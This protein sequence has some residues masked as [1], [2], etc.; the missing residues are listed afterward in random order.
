MRHRAPSS[1]EPRPIV[2]LTSDF[3]LSDHYVA[4]MKAVLVREFPPARLIDITHNVPRHD[5]LCG[6]ITIER[7]VDGFTGGTTHL[8]VVDPGVGTDRRLI[9][10]RLRDQHIVCPDNGLITWAWRVHGGG[11]AFEITWRPSKLSNT[12]HGRDVMAPIAA[13]IARGEDVNLFARPIDDPVLLDLAPASVNDARGRVIHIDHFGNATTNIRQD[14][15]PSSAVVNVKVNRRTIGKLKRTYWDVA[16]G[17]PLALI[18]S[19]GLL[20]IAV[21]DGSAKDDLNIRVGDDVVIR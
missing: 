8:A 15:L 17:K 6:A 9:V 20:E 5:I 11:E 12:F 13:R 1:P 7:A 4:A 14:V 21:R 10:A 19:S 16:P 18:G 2:T 3:G